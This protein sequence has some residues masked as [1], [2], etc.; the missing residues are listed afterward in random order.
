VDVLLE[1]EAELPAEH[2]GVI[3]VSAQKHL[4]HASQMLLIEEILVSQ[5]L[6]I[7]VDLGSLQCDGRDD[8]FVGH[9]RSV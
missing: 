1:L 2:A 6:T 8:R 7:D 3:E 9:C 5:Q 4:V